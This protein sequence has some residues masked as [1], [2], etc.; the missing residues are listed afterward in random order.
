M[1]RLQRYFYA[2]I[3]DEMGNPPSRC[4]LFLVLFGLRMVQTAKA[5]ELL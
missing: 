2:S 5:E 4:F 3:S 1:F